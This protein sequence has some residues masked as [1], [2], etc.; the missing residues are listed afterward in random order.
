[1]N[2][3]KRIT[4]IREHD[5]ELVVWKGEKVIYNNQCEGVLLKRRMDAQIAFKKLKKQHKL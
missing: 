1:M 3:R 4:K 5:Y 2:L